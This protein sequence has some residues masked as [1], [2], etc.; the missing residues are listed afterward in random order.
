M[1]SEKNA[2]CNKSS[3]NSSKYYLNIFNIIDCHNYQWYIEENRKFVFLSK[4]IYIG[5]TI[6]LSK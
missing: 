3:Q 2:I 5:Q 4:K 6:Q 1:H